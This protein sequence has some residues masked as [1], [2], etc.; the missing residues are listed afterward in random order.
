MGVNLHEFSIKEFQSLC[1]EQGL[2]FAD[3]Y[4]EG[5]LLSFCWKTKEPI[6]LQDDDHLVQIIQEFLAFIDSLGIEGFYFDDLHSEFIVF[7]GKSLMGNREFF[8]AYG[9]KTEHRKCQLGNASYG[10]LQEDGT[11]ECY[12]VNGNLISYGISE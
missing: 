1:V 9:N 5:E 4:W 2:D 11:V 12:D 7:N 6:Y 3:V 10:V 8:E